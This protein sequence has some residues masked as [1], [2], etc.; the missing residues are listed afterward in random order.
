MEFTDFLKEYAI[1]IT[2]G[3]AS[4]KSSL[5]EFLRNEGFTVIDADKLSRSLTDR[6]QPALE[7][8]RQAFGD[9]FIDEQ[10]LLNRR[11]MREL[12]FSDPSAKAKLEA[13]IHPRLQE[14]TIEEL[15]KHQLFSHPQ[16]WFYE[17]SLIYERGI[18]DRFR[19]VWLVYCTEQLQL[20]RLTRRDQI[21]SDNAK[22][23]I[24][25]Q[26]SNEAKKQLATFV[27]D[28]S[29]SKQHLFEQ[30]SEHIQRLTHKKDL[31][32]G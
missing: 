12:V 27:L 31:I 7:D 26:L 1:A 22:K 14:A 30:A 4:G 20:E 9:S 24:A 3:I 2:G 21:D 19:E 18:Q 5:C 29:I 32:R 11:K 16:I 25:N 8:I 6:H 10:G 17:A 23:I 13:I 28:S 15:K